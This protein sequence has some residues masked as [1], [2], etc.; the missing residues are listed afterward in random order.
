MVIDPV[1]PTKPVAFNFSLD[2]RM[3]ARKAELER[4]ST[5]QQKHQNPTPVP[6]FKTLHAAHEAELAHRK[7][8]IT[9]VY[10]LPIELKTDVR[11]KERERFDERMRIKERELERAMEERRREQEANEQKEIREFRKRAVP[12]AHTVPVWYN[13]APKRKGGTDSIGG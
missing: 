4:P 3:E 9:P 10:P 12:K 5:S 11:A 7:E 2:A 1:N 13:E 6:D 8:N